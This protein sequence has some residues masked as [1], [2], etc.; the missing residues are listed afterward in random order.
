MQTQSGCEC[1]HMLHASVS[2][3][4]FIALSLTVY[5]LFPFSFCVSSVAFQAHL[6]ILEKKKT[7]CSLI[8]VLFIFFLIKHCVSAAII[9]GDIN[10]FIDCKTK[11]NKT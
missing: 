11:L 9:C 8:S 5:F 7:V 3:F 6:F 1:V 2:L 10:S 4:L